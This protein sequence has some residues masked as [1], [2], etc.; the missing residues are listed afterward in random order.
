MLYSI[1]LSSLLVDLFNPSNWCVE[2]PNLL[3]IAYSNNQ[4][5][6]CKCQ[7]QQK[8]I[9][10]E[11]NPN[12]HDPLCSRLLIIMSLIFSFSTISGVNSSNIYIYIYVFGGLHS[13]HAVCAR[14]VLEVM[15]EEK[16][17][18][19]R[20]SMPEEE[21]EEQE[22]F[23]GFEDLECECDSSFSSLISQEDSTSIESSQNW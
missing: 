2:S 11:E 20:W 21:E 14:Q 9:K 6:N 18:I 8:R 17:D 10:K 7:L 5:F 3:G 23:W 16:T 4:I 12:R 22:E 1:V 13:F 15:E 19:E